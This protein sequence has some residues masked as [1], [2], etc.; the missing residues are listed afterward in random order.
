IKGV[1][2]SKATKGSRGQCIRLCKSRN[3]DY[4]RGHQPCCTQECLLNLHAL[5]AGTSRLGEMLNARIEHGANAFEKLHPRRVKMFARLRWRASVAQELSHDR[6]QSGAQARS[7]SRRLCLLIL[8]IHNVSSL[9][10]MT[11]VPSSSRARPGT[12]PA[13]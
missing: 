4:Q 3:H 5:A 7:A 8:P 13:M 1:L 10:S 2:L 12:S 9:S 6:P 11:S